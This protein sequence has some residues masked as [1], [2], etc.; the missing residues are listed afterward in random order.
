MT[1]PMKGIG[2]VFFALELLATLAYIFMRPSPDGLVFYTI[3]DDLTAG[4][5][6]VNYVKLTDTSNP[7]KSA[8]YY[9]ENT[10]DAISFEIVDVNPRYRSV[11]IW[12]AQRLMMRTQSPTR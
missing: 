11:M 8:S 7:T 6:P 10:P 12:K 5:Y 2:D 4:M 3:P 1:Q 9:L